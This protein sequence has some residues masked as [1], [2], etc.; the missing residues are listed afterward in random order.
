MSQFTNRT[1]VHKELETIGLKVLIPDS[2]VVV[3]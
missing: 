3:N 2:Q 1:G